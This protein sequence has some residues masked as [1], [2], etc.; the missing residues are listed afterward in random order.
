[1]NIQYSLMEE[2][3]N[4]TEDVYQRRKEGE[5]KNVRVNCIASKKEKKKDHWMRESERNE[6]WRKG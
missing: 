3:G 5:E 6:I 4:G 1:M 2:V